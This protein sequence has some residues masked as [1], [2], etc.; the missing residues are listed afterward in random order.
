MRRRD[1]A[2]AGRGAAQPLRGQSGA[3]RRS[4]RTEL[5]WRRW[6]GGWRRQSGRAAGRAVSG[7]RRH[8]DQ[9]G[10]DGAGAAAASGRSSNCFEGAP[11]VVVLDGLQDPGNAGTIVRAAEA[12]GAT[13]VVFL[14]GTVSPYN[15]K[16]LRASA[17]SLFR[18]PFVHGV[19]AAAARAALQQ[20][21]VDCSPPCRR[22]R[23][24]RRALWRTAR[25][26][27]ALRRSSSAA[28]RMAYRRECA[29]G[30]GAMCPFPRWAWNR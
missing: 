7:N 29:V 26:D 11:L 17:G 25:S 18:V 22:S 6:A 12:F 5:W 24:N 30:R 27:R 10:R 14:K 13:G 28:R 16:T 20:G 21:R 8:G 23:R 3:G 4:R 15:P 9:S 2:P 19:E 1:L